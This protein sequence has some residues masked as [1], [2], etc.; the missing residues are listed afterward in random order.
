MDEDELKTE[1][2][3]EQI[4]NSNSAAP[5]LFVITNEMGI[6]GILDNMFVSRYLAPYAIGMAQTNFF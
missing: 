2:K 5:P 4:S 1:E 6:R 3:M